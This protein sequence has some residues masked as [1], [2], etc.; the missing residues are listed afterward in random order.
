MDPKFSKNS[1]KKFS[2]EVMPRTARKVDNFKRILPY[3]TTVYVAHL[4]DTPIEEMFSTCKR[5]IS[6]GMAPMPHIPARIISNSGNLED[7]VKEYASL[8]VEQSLLLAGNRMFS[9]YLYQN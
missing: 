8:G 3:K 9:D 1:S 2:L 5:L 4:E 7:W 6:E